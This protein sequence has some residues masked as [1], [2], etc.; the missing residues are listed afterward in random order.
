[1]GKLSDKVALITGAARGQGRAHASGLAAAGADIIALDICAQIDTAPYP[2]GSWEDLEETARLVRKTGRR[3]VTIQCDVRDIAAMRKAVAHGVSEFGRL[4]IVV[5]NAGIMSTVGPRGDDD[6]A[7]YDSIDVMLTGVWHTLRAATPIM[8]DQG[9]GGSIVITSSTAG[10]RGIR[11]HLEAGSAGY[12]AAKHAVVGLMRMYANLLAE[13]SIRVNTVHPTGVDTPM[14]RNAAFEA[15]ANDYPH[16]VQSL[17]NALPKPLID[18]EDVTNAILW[19]VSDDARYVTGTTMPV[20][21]GFVVR[22]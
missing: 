7:F 19:L 20:D 18:P 3:A 21:A 8:I 11:T 13:H 9:Q 16:L 15:F 6:Q 14:V 5:A 17:R 1:M 2:L 12:V 10:L 4:D 22:A